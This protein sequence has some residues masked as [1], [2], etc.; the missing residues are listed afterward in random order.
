MDKLIIYQTVSITT[1]MKMKKFQSM[2]HLE[3][4]LGPETNQ[5]THLKPFQVKFDKQNPILRVKTC[6]F[7]LLDT[8]FCNFSTIN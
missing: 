4:K 8:K 5:Q 3:N 1:Q 7:L 2:L 6:R